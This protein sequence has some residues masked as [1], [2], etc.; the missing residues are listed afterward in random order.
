MESILSQAREGAEIIVPTDRLARTIRLELAESSEGV[1]RIPRVESFHHWVTRQWAKVADLARPRVLSGA[2][3]L[4]AIEKVVISS[5]QGSDLLAPASLVRQVRRAL[6]TQLAYQV[7]P[8]EGP[9]LSREAQAFKDWGQ[10]LREFL[11]EKNACLAS[12]TPRLLAEYAKSGLWVAPAQLVVIGQDLMPGG[13]QALFD[14][15]EA[16]GSTVELE[17]LPAAEA[18]TPHRLVRPSRPDE[19]SAW[20]ARDIRSLLDEKPDA[21]VLVVCPDI[22]EARDQLDRVFREVLTPGDSLPGASANE[23][24]WRFSKGQPLS[25]HPLV[26][27]ALDVL[28]L[29]A[30]GNPMQLVSRV[31]LSSVTW[32]DVHVHERAS[33]DY[34]LRTSGAARLAFADILRRYRRFAGADKDWAYKP[35]PGIRLARLLRVLRAEGSGDQLPSEWVR[36]FEARLDAIGWSDRVDSA[37]YQVRSMFAAALAQ[38]SSLDS[39]LGPVPGSSALRWLHEVLVTRR[40]SVRSRRDEPLFVCE[41]SEAVGLSCDRLYL[42]SVS[43]SEFPRPVSTPAFFTPEALDQAEVPGSTCDHV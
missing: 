11:S 32:G 31:L 15:M 18:V 26:N 42:I 43:S 16:Q 27:S 8:P 35:H 4:A 10:S 19:E 36:R 41:P 37:E 38:L 2:E 3:A 22:E 33:L 30:V 39:V 29:N 40:V 24:L 13:A 23:S 12:E 14:S 9:F 34:A 6:D 20:I 28:H 1:W 21:K 5:E 7:E 25:D 17:A